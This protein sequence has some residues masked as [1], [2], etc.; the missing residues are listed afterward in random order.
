MILDPASHNVFIPAA[1]TTANPAGRGRA[2]P[3]AG[4]FK[5]LMLGMIP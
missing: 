2:V 1:M 4:S 3:V 5:V